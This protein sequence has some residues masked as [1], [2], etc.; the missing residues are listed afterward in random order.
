MNSKPIHPVFH[1]I[2]IPMKLDNQL[3][4]C[5]PGT[6]TA[7][8]IRPTKRLLRLQLLATCESPLR[9]VGLPLLH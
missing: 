2:L 8:I 6:G 1:I 9:V 4:P 7:A 3:I 5:D